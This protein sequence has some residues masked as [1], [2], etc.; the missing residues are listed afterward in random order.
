MGVAGLVEV[1]RKGGQ[2]QDC[3]SGN[4]HRPALEY[5]AALPVTDQKRTGGDGG[6]YQVEKMTLLCRKWSPHLLDLIPSSSRAVCLNRWGIWISYRGV[7]CE[8]AYD[9]LRRSS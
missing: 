9:G 3:H 8:Q 5:F 4:R 2:P 1:S 7:T 6:G